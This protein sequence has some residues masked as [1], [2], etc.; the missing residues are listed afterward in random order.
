MT[1]VLEKRESIMSYA[2]QPAIKEIVKGLSLLMMR[3]KADGKDVLLTEGGTG[4]HA[5]TPIEVTIYEDYGI[6]PLH[7]DTR[8]VKGIKVNKKGDLA[9]FVS[10]DVVVYTEEDL[11]REFDDETNEDV[12][13]LLKDGELFTGDETLDTEL[14]ALSLLRN[15][16]EYYS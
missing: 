4:E 15:I 16:D 14:A 2:Y 5:K 10:F 9:I 3:L 13:C 8:E 11:V 1:K 12:H 6:G 7:P